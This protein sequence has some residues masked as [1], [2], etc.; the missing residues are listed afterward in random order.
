MK[1]NGGP[2][3]GNGWPSISIRVRVELHRAILKS[4]DDGVGLTIDPAYVRLIPSEEDPY[5]WERSS[6]KE[7]LFEKHHSML[8]FGPLMELEKGWGRPFGRYARR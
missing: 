4:S 7:Y 2:S 8:C 6:E 3:V 1:V 5:R